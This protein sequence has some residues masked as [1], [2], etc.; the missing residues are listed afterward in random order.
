MKYKFQFKSVTNEELLRRLSALVQKSRQVEAELIAHIGEVDDRRLYARYASSMFVF[1]RERLH[2]S[3]HEAYLRIEVARASRKHPVLLEMLAEGRLHLSG[4]SLLHR[5]L[6]D[7]N[8]DSLL[9]RAAHQSKRQIEE[10]VAELSP[11]PDVPATIRKLPQRRETAQPKRDE[12]LGPDLVD[13]PAAPAQEP[14]AAVQPLS[15][16][17][18]K[19]QFTAGAELHD[20]LERLKALTRSSV[21]DGDLATIIEEAVTEK[22]ERLESKRFGK[23]KSPRKNL[24]E[25]DTSPSSRHIPATVKRTVYER[26]R[27]QCRYEDPQGRRC[28]ERHRL[29]YHHIQPFGRG[30]D[31]SPDN[32]Q[33]RCRAHNRYEAERDYGKEMMERYI[34]YGRSPDRVSEPATIYSTS[35]RNLLLESY[36]RGS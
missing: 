28:T 2:L 26:D 1:C 7:E 11:K 13:A 32:V 22:L 20:K 16:A 15:P 5:H 29:E 17:R 23:T 21:P 25:T 10:L 24:E 34:K 30:G 6:T 14:P 36:A 35:Y 4:I 12:V 31:H 19:I 27:G 9:E 33:L 8:R 3:E 18:Y